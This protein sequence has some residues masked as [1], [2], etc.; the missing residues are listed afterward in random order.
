[1]KYANQERAQRHLQNSKSQKKIDF[2]LM[3]QSIKEKQNRVQQR[4]AENE[5]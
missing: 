4:R 2:Q 3:L 1:M 5:D